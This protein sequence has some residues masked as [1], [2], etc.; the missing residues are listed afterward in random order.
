MYIQNIVDAKNKLALD[1][2]Q[3]L[4]SPL[5]QIGGLESFDKRTIARLREDLFHD[6]CAVC[7]QAGMPVPAMEQDIVLAQV[8]EVSD[9]GQKM[10]DLL[11]K[12]FVRPA[13]KKFK[14][15]KSAN[16][17][18]ARM[19]LEFLAKV[20]G[21]TEGDV[22]VKQIECL[23]NQVLMQLGLEP[24]R[25]EYASRTVQSATEQKPPVSGKKVL[26]VD[27]RKE[28]IIRTIRSLA[29]WNGLTVSYYQYF[30]KSKSW[31]ASP[32]EVQDELSRAAREVLELSPD[33]ILMDQGLAPIEG[34]DLVLAIRKLTSSPP[35][36]V[37]NTG[38]SDEKLRNVG[39]L[40]NCGKGQNLRGMVQAV[41]T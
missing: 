36:F 40:A 7:V 30:P 22:S 16:A 15:N 19:F 31:G 41:N 1:I 26:V 24:M 27:D 33:V 21:V 10:H 37:A 28:E 12:E 20:P 23:V 14:G 8:P 5:T 38:G 18:S 32:Q 25:P 29:G 2:A 39:S 3:L 13:R 17:K 35:I 9:R 34:N 4:D 6:F 11:M